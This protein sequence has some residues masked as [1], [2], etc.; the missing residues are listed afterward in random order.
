MPDAI[1]KPAPLELSRYCVPFTPFEK[2][3][4]SSRVCLV[5]TAGVYARGDAPLVASGDNTFRVIPG[6]ATSKDLAYA[7][8]HYPHDCVDADLNCVFPLDRLHELAAEKVIAGVAESHFSMGF[9]QQ[10]AAIR[11]TTVPLLARAVDK[12]RPDA[13]VLTG[14]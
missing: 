12:V 2:P 4:G 13:V 6:G 5:S 3:L 7:D 9:T 10:L 11:S 14:G 8:E 1:E